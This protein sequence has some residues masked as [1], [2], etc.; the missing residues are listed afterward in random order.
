MVKTPK[1]RE[2]TISRDTARL[3]SQSTYHE[4]VLALR[5]ILA[6]AHDA[7]SPTADVSIRLVD[8]KGPGG[9]IVVA[10]RGEGMD[11]GTFEKVFLRLGSSSR[12]IPRPKRLNQY[13]RPLIGRF[14]IGFIAAVPFAEKIRVETATE[15]CAQVHGVEIDCSEI[16]ES[17]DVTGLQGAEGE[18]VSVSPSEVGEAPVGA[19]LPG[20][21]FPGWD[22]DRVRSDPK[23]FTVVTLE[24]LTRKA[25]DSLDAELQGGWYQPRGERKKSKITKA[26]R[27]EFVTR[28]LSRILPLGYEGP[29]GEAAIR[30][31]LGQ[32]LAP[33]YY[34][35]RVTVNGERLYRPLAKCV[36]PVDPAPFTLKGERSNWKAKGI[37]WSPQEVIKPYYL[38]GVAMRV[39]DVAVGKPSYF[40]INEVGRVYG[41]L[42]HIAGEI[43]LVGFQEYLNLDRQSLRGDE[44]TDE[45]IEQIQNKIIA[46]E[47]DLQTKA[48]VMQ[49][50]R[51]LK[52]AIERSRARKKKRRRRGTQEHGFA[53]VL[54]AGRVAGE[55][56][57]RAREAGI[58]V[59]ETEGNE[60]EIPKGERELRIGKRVGED[61]LLIGRGSKQIPVEIRD[62]GDRM[63]DEQLAKAVLEPSEK[64]RLR[65]GHTL[66]ADD[67]WAVS[68]LRLLAILHLASREG[69]LDEAQIRWLIRE[70]KGLYE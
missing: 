31:A 57:A 36:Y 26:R 18:G 23:S 61:L 2:I 19:D 30:K 14:G 62:Q 66:L 53:D 68:N 15:H 13:G 12:A 44:A 63:D 7:Q 35:L 29:K 10:D 20:F 70:L 43:Q 21:K 34:P 39:S 4:V 54:V 32:M 1:Q 37:L 22:R 27:T 59:T 8:G 52:K 48:A 5:E 46:F 42:Q 65:G 56:A 11:S 3:L 16:M 45:L 9:S 17:K 49:Q 64:L 25:Y 58:E 51:N 69:V 60:L 55:I 38:R 6:N 47:H 50:A 24:S 33:D 28:W 67:A 40:N 41:K